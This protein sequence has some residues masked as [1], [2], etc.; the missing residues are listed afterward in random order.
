MITFLVILDYL[1]SHCKTLVNARCRY[2]DRVEWS[3]GHVSAI[4]AI[5]LIARGFYWE[6]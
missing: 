6:C 5:H 4:G 2:R 1:V 3:K